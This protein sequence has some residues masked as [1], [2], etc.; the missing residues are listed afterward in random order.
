MISIAWVAFFSVG[1]LRGNLYWIVDSVGAF[2]SNANSTLINLAAASHGQRV[3]ANVDRLLTLAVWALGA[4]GFVRLLRR[5]QLELTAAV[6]AVAPFGMLG[7]TSYGGEILFRVYFFSLPFFALLAAGSLLSRRVVGRRL[8]SRA[9]P[10]GREPWRSSPGSSSATTARRRRTT[11]PRRGRR[12]A[13]ALRERT[14]GV[15]VS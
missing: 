8:A 7:A 5:G 13:R 4:L 10:C 1:F 3:V 12:G 11:S 9:S 14:G 2:S 6:L 15:A